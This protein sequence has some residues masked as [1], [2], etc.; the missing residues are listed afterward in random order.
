MRSCPVLLAFLQVELAIGQVREE[1]QET[2]LLQVGL[3]LPQAAESPTALGSSNATLLNASKANV[4]SV[5]SVKSN[6]TA[7]AALS[8]VPRTLTLPTCDYIWGVPKIAWAVVC[9]LLAIAA[10]LLCIPFLLNASRRR[11]YGA[12]ILDLS[13]RPSQGTSKPTTGLSD[14]WPC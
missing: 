4:S 12:P 6:S 1:I 13:F 7:G 9:D 10:L 14:C 5:L 8:H 3:E 11:P 2:C